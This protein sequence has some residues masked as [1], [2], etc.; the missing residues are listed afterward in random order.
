MF[1]TDPAAPLKLFIR[2]AAGIVMIA[3]LGKQNVSHMTGKKA[4]A[5]ADHMTQT[6]HRIKWDPGFDH[7]S[8]WTIRFSI[9]FPNFT[10]YSVKLGNLVDS[11]FKTSAGSKKLL[12]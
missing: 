11:R 2:L 6:G 5:I 4:S 9:R 12:Y 3:I 8:H 7:F 1:K 10:Y